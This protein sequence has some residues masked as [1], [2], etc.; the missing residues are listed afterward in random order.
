MVYPDGQEVE[1]VAGGQLGQMWGI[2]DSLN[3]GRK[4]KGRAEAGVDCLGGM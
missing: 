4:C 3:V 1:A 2:P